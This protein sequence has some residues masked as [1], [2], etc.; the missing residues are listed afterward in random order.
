MALA[1]GKGADLID[2]NQENPP[3]VGYVTSPPKRGGQTRK[4]SGKNIKSNRQALAKKQLHTN[5]SQIF[6]NNNQI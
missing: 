5:S 4:P 3:G 6:N 2:A 1:S